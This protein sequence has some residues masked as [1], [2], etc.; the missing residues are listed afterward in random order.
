M[1][2][3]NC[4]HSDIGYFQDDC[5]CDSDPTE[6]RTVVETYNR[7]FPCDCGVCFSCEIQDEQNKA[8]GR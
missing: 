2:C 4:Y 7:N 1:A 6:D 8:E 5:P 3:P